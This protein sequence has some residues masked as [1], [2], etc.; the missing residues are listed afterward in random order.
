MQ[1]HDHFYKLPLTVVAACEIDTILR[2]KFN[3]NTEC[4]YSYADMRHFL[5]D[6]KSIPDLREG[7]LNHVDILTVTPPC[8][9]RSA[10]N[11]TREPYETD[12]LLLLQVELAKVL[13]PKRILAELTPAN[14]AFNLDHSTVANTISSLGYTVN[15]TER[16]Q[17]DLCYSHQHR[18]RWILLAQRNDF[19]SKPINLSKSYTNYSLPLKEILDKPNHVPDRLWLKERMIQVF[20][21]PIPYA[22]QPV[23]RP[24]LP[25]SGGVQVT[26]G[27]Q[28]E[29]CMLLERINQDSYIPKID[30]CILIGPSTQHHTLKDAMLV[31]LWCVLHNISIRSNT[32]KFHDTFAV[33]LEG[34]GSGLKIAQMPNPS[35]RLDLKAQFSNARCTF[36]V[37]SYTGGQLTF[38]TSTTWPSDLEINIFS[39]SYVLST[40]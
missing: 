40:T 21:D 38:Q 9:G 32:S 30:N 34:N 14:K 18:D 13:K 12:D 35:S 37:G 23:S 36:S 28:S 5:H 17:S 22:N 3:S 4:K 29:L 27:E 15:V 6:V 31:K 26:I 39:Q 24:K 25:Y 33:D 19:I 11:E 20:A 8:Q 2:N 10:L 16:F 7:L 1:G